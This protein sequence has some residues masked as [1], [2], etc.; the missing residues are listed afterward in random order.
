MQ[1]D[2]K[3]VDDYIASLPPERQV[4]IQ[5]VR[6]VILEN[7]PEG[8]KEMMDWGVICYGVPLEVYP[9]TYNKKPLSYVALASQKNHMAVYLMTIYTS[10]EKAKQF[11]REYR[12]TGKRYDV[13]KSCVRFR[14]L[15]DLPL[16]LI[17]AEVRSIEMNDY[18]ELA[19]KAGSNRRARKMK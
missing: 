6:K 17:A 16:P 11:E 3:N 4:A 10:E 14:K 5:E 8:Y 13:G 19:K 15:E 1:S 9:D 12:A 2:A 18:I 7:L